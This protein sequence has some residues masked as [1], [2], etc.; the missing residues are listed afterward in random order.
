MPKK[1]RFESAVHQF[2]AAADR[3]RAA[4]H[5]TSPAAAESFAEWIRQVEVDYAGSQFRVSWSRPRQGELVVP[6]AEARFYVRGDRINDSHAV[7]N[8]DGTS[9]QSLN[10]DPIEAANAAFFERQIHL[11]LAGSGLTEPDDVGSSSAAH[12]ATTSTAEETLRKAAEARFHDDWAAA[13]DV[14]S[15]DVRRMNEACTAPEMRFI[16]QQLGSIQGRRLLD[17]G[18]GLGEAS[19]YFAT[20]GADVTATDI[21]PGMLDAVSRLAAANGVSVRTEL[22]ASEDL[23]LAATEQ[24][25]I[26]YT[27]NTL[28]HVDI[29]Q[30][31][32]KLLPLLKPDGIFLSWDPLAYN[33]VINVYRSLATQVRTEDE[34]PLR[35]SDLRLMKSRFRTS[36]TRYFW[37]TTLAIFLVMAVVQRRDP[38]KERYWK[39]VVEEADAWSWL[40]GPLELFDRLLLT[41][42]PFL[43]PLCWNVVF[44]GKGPLRIG[45]H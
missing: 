39:K 8:G 11:A 9:L 24:F 10:D 40:Y 7:G 12:D 38:N 20:E 30:T 42:F 13:V 4:L 17:V 26:I 6:L 35:L 29:G 33:P 14:R 45:E 19:V 2:F 23:K 27:G 15:I 16:R 44:I 31:L 5:R 1:I 18:C 41:V 32:D 36:H 28:H 25:D 34:H 21:S 37:L 3:H 43:R 22:A